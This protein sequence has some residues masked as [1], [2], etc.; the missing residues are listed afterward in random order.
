[1]AQRDGG[2]KLLT[3]MFQQGDGGRGIL[4]RSFIAATSPPG[5]HIAQ[6]DGGAKLLTN[7]FQQGDGGRGILRRSFIAA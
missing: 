2:A 4:R 3:N 1:I 5:L 7:M 6:R